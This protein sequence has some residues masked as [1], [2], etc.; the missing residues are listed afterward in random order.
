MFM[1]RYVWIYVCL[2]W[3]AGLAGLAGGQAGREEV[4]GPREFRLLGP[5]ETMY[6]S[7]KKSFVLTPFELW[8]ASGLFGGAS[9]SQAGREEEEVTSVYICV[10]ID[11]RACLCTDVYGYVCLAGLAGLAGGGTSGSQAGREEEEVTSVYTCVF[12]D[13]RACLCIDVC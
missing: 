8:W 5:S 2:A 1:H 13:K 4:T 11:K 6:V 3:L 10:F 7:Y 9:G 12:I